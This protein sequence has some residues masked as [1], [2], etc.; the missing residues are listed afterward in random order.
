MKT[1]FRVLIVGIFFSLWWNVSAAQP[2]LEVQTMLTS[3]DSLYANIT[4]IKGEKNMVLVD[5]PFTRSDTHRLIA[6][7][8]E[9][10]KHLET[11]IITHDHP[12]H[13][14]GLDLLMDTF[15]ETKVVAHPQVVRDIW[16]SIPIKFK[17]WNP[18]LGN[19]A[20]HHP[21]VPDAAVEQDG[22]YG[23]DLEGHRVE[24]LGPMQGDHVHATAVWVPSIKALVA[25]DLIYNGM[26]L[27]LGEHLA[28][29]RLAWRKVLDELE[30][31]KPEIVV[32]GHKQQ[33]MPDDMSSIR[34]SKHYL[35]VFE[36]L[37][38]VSKDSKDL[39]ARL[40]KAFPDAIDVVNDF[41]ITYSTQVAMGEIP[42]WDE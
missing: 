4:L 26:F 39:A 20:P 32:A 13:F 38:A 2:A 28:P 11:V 31:L 24:I 36:E 7:I 27:W 16:R 25:G 1:K 21:A 30:A 35:D 41:L 14:F 10:G 15:P 34:F 29:Q 23:V 40:R 42:P 37:V 3:E 17:R 18:M 33:G 19:Q 5:V 6:D 8:L 22:A 9:T 12:D